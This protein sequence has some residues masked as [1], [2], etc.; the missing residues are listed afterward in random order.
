[1]KVLRKVNAHVNARHGL[2]EAA[3]GTWKGVAI[4]RLANDDQTNLNYRKSLI[5]RRCQTLHAGD[6]PMQ[7]EGI[8]VWDARED[9]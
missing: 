4:N 7:H 3:S 2:V 1:M 8:S 9:A 6:G 5:L